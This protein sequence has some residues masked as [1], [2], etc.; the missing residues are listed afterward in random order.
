M[1]CDEQLEARFTYHP[2]TPRQQGSYVVI[3]QAALKLARVI[4]DETPESADQTAALRK[5]LECVMT[6]NAA[7]ACHVEDL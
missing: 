6:A 7:I 4:R 2:P 1:I 5:L 3:C